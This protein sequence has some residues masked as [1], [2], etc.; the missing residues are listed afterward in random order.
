MAFQ[1]SVWVSDLCGTL[2][3]ALTSLTIAVDPRSVS[4]I[5]WN[6]DG[7]DGGSGGYYTNK[8]FDFE[9]CP[10]FGWSDPFTTSVE[11]PDAAGEFSYFITSTIGPPYHPIVSPIPELHVAQ[12]AYSQCSAWRSVGYRAEPFYGAYDPPRALRPVDAMAAP[13]SSAATIDPATTA[14]AMPQ[15]TASVELPQIT[16]SAF[17]PVLPDLQPQASSPAPVAGAKDPNRPTMASET[18]DTHEA[19]HPTTPSL[20]LKPQGGLSSGSDRAQ[21]EMPT[22]GPQGE[23]DPSTRLSTNG[24]STDPKTAGVASADE[25]NPSPIPAA[26]TRE[27]LAPL[28]GESQKVQTPTNGAMNAKGSSE[29]ADSHVIAPGATTSVPDG[30]DVSIDRGSNAKAATDS[31]DNHVKATVMTLDSSTFTVDE[32]T[33]LVIEGQ[34]LKQGQAITV[35][36]TPI[37]YVTGGSNVVVGSITQALS[38]TQVEIAHETVITFGGSTYTASSSAFV[39]HGQTL[40]PGGAITV[41]STPLS[42]KSGG[43]ELVIGTSTQTL[44]ATAVGV[45]EH[46]VVAFAGSTYTEKS[47][48]FII[49]GQ[50]LTPGGA[51]T[52]ADTTL[53][54]KSGDSEIVIGTS[55]QTLPT[56]AVPVTEH[57]VV[58][59]AGSTY[60]A[61]SS[62][63]VI[64]GQTLSKGSA[65]TVS[66][67]PISFAAAGTDVVVGSSTQ[68][69]DLGS[70]IMGG[71][72][73]GPATED[74]P[75]S[76]SIGT[77]TPFMGSQP[78]LKINLQLLYYSIA[79]ATAIVV[80][81]IW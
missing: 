72:R 68:A 50:T 1:G 26:S 74:G 77:P 38:A 75:R 24:G 79:I 49:H 16:A 48:A 65:I 33:H 29:A 28:A 6:A 61:K 36:S 8:P 32:N 35:H 37:S 56:T 43:S 15:Q 51:I 46:P 80:L 40:T 59:F 55:T 39:V 58:T 3:S 70:Y 71:F 42:Y 47:S 14:T 57:P 25:A 62:E 30:T 60:T 9:A 19:P 54:Y 52:V 12:P 20:S 78:R 4:S 63:F 13:T 17:D 34:T 5:E 23:I 73:T 31:S 10:T 67:T 45:M 44:P 81:M 53:S 76:N 18:S 64:H 7:A 41:A 22:G 2:G 21:P 66:G 69:V 11:N 27:T